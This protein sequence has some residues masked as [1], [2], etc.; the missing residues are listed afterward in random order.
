MP[1][2]QYLNLRWKAQS[3]PQITN[4]NKNEGKSLKIYF[5]FLKRRGRNWS[6]FIRERFRLK[7]KKK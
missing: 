3:L 1:V 7:E 2:P 5:R 6:W 4:V